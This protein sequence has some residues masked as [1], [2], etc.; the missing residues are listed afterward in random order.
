MKRSLHKCSLTLR[1]IGHTH[2]RTRR[3]VGGGG[4][5]RAWKF[6]EQT[7]FSGQALVAKILND[8]KYFNTGK[9][10]QGNRVF[11]G[12]LIKNPER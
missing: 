4:R 3:G 8:K 10:F 9:N 11:Q 12:K 6:W 1:H 2:R 5:P 7:L